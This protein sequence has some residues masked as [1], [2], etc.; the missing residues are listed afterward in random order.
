MS[1]KKFQYDES[2]DVELEKFELKLGENDGCDIAIFQY[3][4]SRPKVQFSKWFMKYGEKQYKK[5]GRLSM[6]ECEK[7]FPKAIEMLK[8]YNTVKKPV[9]NHSKVIV[10]NYV[11]DLQNFDKDVPF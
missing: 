8:K 11:D 10:D 1:D 4:E 3:G 7:I 5:L 6:F 9:D 2:I